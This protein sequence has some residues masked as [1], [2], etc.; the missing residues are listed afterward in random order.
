MTPKKALSI[1]KEANPL[2]Y[3]QKGSGETVIKPDKEFLEAV[4][5]IENRLEAFDA[6]EKEI[7]CDITIIFKVLN[8]GAWFSLKDFYG[9][10]EEDQTMFVECV[11]LGKSFILCGTYTYDGER[12]SVSVLPEHY[13]Q[14]WALT[15]EELE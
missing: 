9:I 13:G 15:K 12:R 8:N 10:R 2:Y 6:I 5:A 4:K 1:I 7:G 3:T 11:T 14:T